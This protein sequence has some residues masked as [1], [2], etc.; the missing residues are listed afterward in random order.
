MIM[1]LHDFDPIEPIKKPNGLKFP[2]T[3]H[4]IEELKSLQEIEEQVFYVFP[5]LKQKQSI[6]VNLTRKKKN[7]TQ[8]F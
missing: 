2:V 7:K 6:S 5:R 1:F 4:E 3:L 8:L